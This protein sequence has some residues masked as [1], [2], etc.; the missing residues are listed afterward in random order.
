MLID[1]AILTQLDLTNLL[2]FSFLA[3][4]F[5]VAVYFAYAAD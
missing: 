4:L 5:A 3:W 2:T 1:L